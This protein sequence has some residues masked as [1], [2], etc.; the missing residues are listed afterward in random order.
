LSDGKGSGPTEAG[1]HARIPYLKK[2]TERN[3]NGKG[4]VIK[5]G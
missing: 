3:E 5:P 4:P 1:N 2:E